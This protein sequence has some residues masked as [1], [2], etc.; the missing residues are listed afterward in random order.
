MDTGLQDKVAIVTGAA[1]GIG[2]ATARLLVAEGARVALL[3]HDAAGLG[4]LATEL[5]DAVTTH[6]ADLSTGPGVTDTVAAAIAAHG[7]RVDVLVNNV[8][9]GAVRTFDQLTDEDWAATLELNFM[10][11]IRAIRAVLPTMRA[12]GSGSIVTNASDLARQPEPSPV[13]YGA[14][15]AALLAVTTSLARAE[16]PQ[17]RVNAVAPGPIWTPFWSKPGGFA[18]TMGQHYGLPPKEAVEHEMRQR[19]LPLGRLG[20]PEEVA[21]AIV[22]LASDLASFVTSSVWGVDGGSIRGI[23]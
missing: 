15:K 9:A 11:A 4:A 20:E 14:S 3:D 10:S 6:A 16:G 2:A 21:N 17:I 22:F 8:G 13:D 1:S 23:L 7:D 18:E 19:Q 12:Q 5:G